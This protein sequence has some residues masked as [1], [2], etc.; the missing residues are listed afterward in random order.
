MKII[1]LISIIFN[2][3]FIIIILKQKDVTTKNIT[4]NDSG[5][6]FKEVFNKD[7]QMIAIVSI[8]GELINVNKSLCDFLKIEADSIIGTEYWTLPWFENS[9]E[10]QN[11]LIFSMEKVYRGE[12]IRFE[13]SYI[14]DLK[15][16]HDIDFQIRPIVSND[17]DIKSFI[18]MGYNI[19]DL[20]KTKDALTKKEYQL[21]S[22][23]HYAKDGYFFYLLDSGVLLKDI[24]DEDIEEIL[25]Y[26]KMIRWNKTL[27][28]QLNIDENN[29][30]NL[31]LF[32]ILSMDKER[33]IPIFSQVIK[34]GN[35]DFLL[36]TKSE[37]SNTEF[38]LDVSIIALK[39]SKNEYMGCFSVIHDITKAKIYE[40]ELEWYANR[41]PLTTL[42][43]RRS[44]F[45]YM[46]N[47]EQIHSDGIMVMM[48]IDHFKK[49][50]DKYGHDAGDIVLKEV[51]KKIDNV[52]VSNA[53]A[54][55]YGGEEFAGIIFDE[56][57]DKVV[58]LCEGLR[59]EIEESV[60]SYDKWD[61]KVTIS[62]GIAKIYRN[63][64][65][66]KSI[67]YA[68][69]ALYTSKETGRNKVTIY[70]DAL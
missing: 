26:H 24:S 63:I 19:T 10:I 58:E 54:C 45:S 7:T 49:V 16:V 2:I 46:K 55:R 20:V 56:N 34:K 53:M 17:G 27:L 22:L 69:N 36:H 61:I 8:D 59:R 47:Q 15:K 38:Y 44:F 6:Y 5:Y 9:E 67:T 60:Y 23:F 30:S 29:L 66:E 35:V 3:I 18:M 14:D 31:E 39:N 28:K 1:L 12:L 37:E 57:I 4:I 52:F 50:N 48:D 42:N 43:N 13:I 64:G 51:A 33:L 70:N 25:K 32:E 41:D 65:F 21:D 68:D 40:K 62:I 11:K